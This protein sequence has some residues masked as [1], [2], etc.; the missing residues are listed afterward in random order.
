MDYSTGLILP[1]EHW[2]NIDGLNVHYLDWSGGGSPLLALHGMASSAYWYE[3]VAN[4]LSEYHRIIAPDQRG[5]G[6]TAQASTGYDWETLA[7]DLVGLLDYLELD[8]VSVVGHSWGGH[9]A[10]NLAA[11]HPD[12]INSLIMID[13]GFQ[14][15]HLLPNATEAFFRERFK[16]RNVSGD[17]E[18]FLGRLKEQLANCWGDDLEKIVLSMVYENVDGLMEDILQ[19]SHHSQILTAMWN[20]PPSTVIP[21][22]NCPILIIPAG[23]KPERAHTEF[24]RMREIMVEAVVGVAKDVRVEWIM[25]TIHDIG[26]DK[27]K[28]LADVILRYV[29][30]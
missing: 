4:H 7:M 27:P 8:R 23:P 16:P 25:D 29:N 10:S 15:G 2:V 30:R 3:R 9:V 18:E 17:R 13:G 24:S 22:I 1:E 14:D 6:Q 20:E 19:P 26:Y 28:E 11:R 12:R 21:R 5:H